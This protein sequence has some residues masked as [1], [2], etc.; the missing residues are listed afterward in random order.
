VPGAKNLGEYL[1]GHGA[2]VPSSG[3]NKEDAV[4]DV[5][6]LAA[7]GKIVVVALAALLTFAAVK[8]GDKL[9]GAKP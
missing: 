5:Q 4:A 7:I 8:A 2:V 6:P 1:L 9:N 3:R